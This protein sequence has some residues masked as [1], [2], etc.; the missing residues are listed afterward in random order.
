[1]TDTKDLK[2]SCLYKLSKFEGFGWYLKFLYFY[3]KHTK[4]NLYN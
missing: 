1:M 2:E 3:F 4:D